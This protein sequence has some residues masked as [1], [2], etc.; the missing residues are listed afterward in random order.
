MCIT[1]SCTCREHN[2]KCTDMCGSCE[3]KCTNRNNN[4]DTVEHITGDISD[5][6]DLPV[7]AHL[8]GWKSDHDI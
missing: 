4:T 2:L 8:L 1:M 5:N 7:L 3:V 6:E